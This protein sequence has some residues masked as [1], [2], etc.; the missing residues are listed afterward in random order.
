MRKALNENQTVQ[1][2]VL[3]V[4]G[5]VFAI[6]IY[7]SVLSGDSAPPPDPSADASAAATATP[8]PA[9]PAPATP[10]AATG[11]PA[12]APPAPAPE[13]GGSAIAPAG[14][15][16]PSEGLPKDVLVPLAKGKAVALIVYDPKAISDKQV[17]AHTD[18]LSSRDDVAVVNVKVKNIADYS[19]ITQGLTVSR[20]PALVV[21]SPRR[22]QSELVATVSYGFRG[23]RSVVTALEDALYDGSSGTAAP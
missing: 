14:D 11:T 13:S 1:L 21:V 5:V 9:T 10:P 4:V 16:A 7:T 3:G 6:I 18:R 15:L 2:A 22:G 23:E 20:T 8:A 12:P 17:K 19:R